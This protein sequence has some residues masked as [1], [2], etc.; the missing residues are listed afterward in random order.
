M[1]EFAFIDKIA[2]R[3]GPLQGVRV[4]IGDDA[5]ILDGARWD[6]V[7]VDTMV[8]GIHF[9]TDFSSASDVG[10]KL[11]ARNL[12]DIAAM[13]GSPGPFFLAMCLGESADEVFLKGFW[14]GVDEAIQDMVPNPGACGPAGGDTTGSPGP[15]M[16]SLTLMGE[17]PRRP[18]LRSGARAGNRILL[19]GTVGLAMA[20]LTHLM[21]TNPGDASRLEFPEAVKAHRRPRIYPE[22]GAFLGQMP[23]ACAMIDVSDGLVQDL[24]HI[25]RA[26]G[27]GARLE[28]ENIP[29]HPESLALARRYKADALEWAL[30]GGDDYALLACVEDRAIDAIQRRC[31]QWGIPFAEIGELLEAGAGCTLWN[32]RGEEVMLRVAGHEHTLGPQREGQKT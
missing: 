18:V 17:G 13:G 6:L 1:R 16:L 15:V 12:S 7:A 14:E 9:R 26:S 2:A 23:G 19:L 30:T 24:G 22:L 8:E 21:H 10:W 5:A 11:L 32:R 25:L 29:L 28:V 20:G 31:A 27:V 4:G 3:T